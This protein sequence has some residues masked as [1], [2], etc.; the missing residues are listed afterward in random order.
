[1]EVE[2]EE[3]EE[4]MIE[5]DWIGED[6]PMLADKGE[7]EWVLEKLCDS[8]NRFIRRNYGP[9]VDTQLGGAGQDVKVTGAR[10]TSSGSTAP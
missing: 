10:G 2:L 4:G 1:M 6:S 9:D 8:L 5:W 3:E 7:P